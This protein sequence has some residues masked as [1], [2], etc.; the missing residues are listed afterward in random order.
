MKEI[1]AATGL[2]LK[3]V[4]FQRNRL[5]DDFEVETVEQLIAIVA[6]LGI[7]KFKS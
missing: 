3:T 6:K 2:S 4:E 5:R 7:E 1:A